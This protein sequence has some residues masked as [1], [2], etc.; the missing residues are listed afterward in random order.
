MFFGS[1]L[2]YTSIRTLNMGVDL[3]YSTIGSVKNMVQ[4]DVA[5]PPWNIKR[6]LEH[7]GCHSSSVSSTC[8]SAVLLLARGEDPLHVGPIALTS[9]VARVMEKLVNSRLL[10]Y[11]LTNNLIYT[12]QS[13]FLPPHSTVTQLAIGLCQLTVT[14]ARVKTSLHTC[15]F[16]P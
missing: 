4:V 7:I 1:L 9:C 10:M 16:L 11:S 13:G 15:F 2:L 12:H 6:P 3:Y 5:C 8:K 14:T